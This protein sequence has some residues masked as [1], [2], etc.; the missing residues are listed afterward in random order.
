[1]SNKRENFKHSGIRKP[2]QSIL[3]CTLKDNF[4]DPHPGR[5]LVS[6]GLAGYQKFLLF[7][8]RLPSRLSRHRAARLDIELIWHTQWDCDQ[9]PRIHF[10]LRPRTQASQP[11][12]ILEHSYCQTSRTPFHTW[13]RKGIRELNPKLPMH[14]RP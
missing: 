11:L 2:L 9:M 13:S 12:E 1:M 5:F 14:N 10:E 8:S 7:P 6:S 4:R 3:S